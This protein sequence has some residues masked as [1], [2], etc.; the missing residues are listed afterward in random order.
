MEAGA[1]DFVGKPFQA[2][3]LLI[4]VRAMFKTAHILDRVVRLEQYIMAIHE[5]R[6]HAPA[7]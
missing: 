2:R 1:D 7:V 3:E 5:M 4:R 6:A